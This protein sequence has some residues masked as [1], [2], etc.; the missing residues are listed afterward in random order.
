MV[1]LNFPF[2]KSFKS[3][4][5][6]SD[7][8]SS[9]FLQHSTKTGHKNIPYCFQYGRLQHYLDLSY[10]TM[11]THFGTYFVWIF[12][13]PF[14]NTFISKIKTQT[15]FFFLTITWRSLCC[16]LS[17]AGVQLC[18]LVSPKTKLETDRGYRVQHSRKRHITYRAWNTGGTFLCMPA[19]TVFRRYFSKVR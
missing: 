9:R 13:K 2:L 11:L 17:G 19:G 1:S 16:G 12:K 14:Q 7:A 18:G 10:Y 5:L 4:V 8:H 6:C 3:S 15:A